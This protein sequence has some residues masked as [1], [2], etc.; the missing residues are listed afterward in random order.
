M[1]RFARIL[2]CCMVIGGTVAACPPIHIPGSGMSMGIAPAHANPPGTICTTTTCDQKFLASGITSP[3]GGTTAQLVP[4][5]PKI[6]QSYIDNWNTET[7]QTMNDNALALV[8][9]QG[10]DVAT[11]YELIG[12]AQFAY[13]PETLKG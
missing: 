7:M 12:R 6:C 11:A 1:K 13:C 2:L 4:L 8:Q 3:S 5:A 10:F 9:R